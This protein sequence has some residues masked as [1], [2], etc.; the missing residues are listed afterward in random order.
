MSSLPN[1]TEVKDFSYFQL[2]YHAVIK[3]KGPF[4][5]GTSQPCPETNNEIIFLMSLSKRL[6][7]MLR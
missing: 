3:D 2:L 7:S 1:E 5:P 6:T 4:D